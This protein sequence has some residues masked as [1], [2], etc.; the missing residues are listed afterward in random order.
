MISDNV[1]KYFAD[2]VY[3]KT[4]IFYPEKDFYRLDIRIN[5]LIDKYECENA[6]KLHQKFM[7]NKTLEME[8]FLIDIC[9]NNETYFFRDNKPFDALVS[10]ILPELKK[11]NNGAPVKIWSCASSTGQEALSISM[12]ILESSEP[13]TIFSIDATDISSQALDKAKSGVYTGL[14]VQRGLPIQLMVKYFES[15]EDSKWK[16]KAELMKYTTFNFFNLFTDIYTLKKYDV[17]FCR[18]VLIYQDMENKVEIIANL[19]RSLKVGGFLVLGAG[20]SLINTGSKLE[21]VSMSGT[22]VFQ[23]KS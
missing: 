3:K 6:D 13:S 22:M 19:E 9:T 15:V 20:E 7:S 1:Y 23:K 10:G 16:A 8:T 12:S 5:K 21:Q 4:G 11:A 17:I 14:D 2:I 18:N